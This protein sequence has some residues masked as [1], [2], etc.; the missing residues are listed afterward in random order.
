MDGSPSA[1]D[2]P[3][4]TIRLKI[5]RGGMQGR[6]PRVPLFRFGRSQF[7]AKLRIYNTGVPDTFFHFSSRN[8]TDPQFPS[9]IASQISLL[10]SKDAGSKRPGHGAA[11]DRHAPLHADGEVRQAPSGSAELSVARAAHLQLRPLEQQHDD[12]SDRLWSA[13]IGAMLLLIPLVRKVERRI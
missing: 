8:P 6:S 9:P 2:Y 1:Q 4:Y 11:G 7:S 12:G 5:D 3:P 10:E 13:K